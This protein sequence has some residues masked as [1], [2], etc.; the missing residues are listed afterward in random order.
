MEFFSK[1]VDI[2]LA[3]IIITGQEGQGNKILSRN[4]LKLGFLKNSRVFI[5]QPQ[6]IEEKAASRNISYKVM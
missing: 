2:N 6:N 1:L 3:K 4:L 5:H